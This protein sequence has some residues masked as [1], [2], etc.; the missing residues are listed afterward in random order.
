MSLKIPDGFGSGRERAFLIRQGTV[1]VEDINIAT[2]LLCRCYRHRGGEVLNEYAPG[3]YNGT[4]YGKITRTGEQIFL[5][6]IGGDAGE[7]EQ[8]RLLFHAGALLV[9]PLDWKKNRNMLLDA[10]TA[11]KF[12]FKCKLKAGEVL[13]DE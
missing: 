2:M 3:T 10:L 9:D 6:I 4:E 8:R 7:H 11:A 13:G 5:F 1:A 12:E